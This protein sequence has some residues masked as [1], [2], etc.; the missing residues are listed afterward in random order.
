MQRLQKSDSLKLKRGGSGNK[1]SEAYIII[2]LCAGEMVLTYQLYIK[3]FYRYN[4]NMRRQKN[5]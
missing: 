5:L 1:I 4:G 3:I 2:H